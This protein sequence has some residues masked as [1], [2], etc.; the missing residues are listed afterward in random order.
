MLELGWYSNREPGSQ[1][2]RHEAKRARRFSRSRNSGG[3]NGGACTAAAFLE[4]FIED[5][6]P[7]VHIDIAGVTT[8][9]APTHMAPKGATGW[10]VAALDELVRSRE[11]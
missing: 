3:R 10:G 11:T 2:S 7:W 1:L 9:A 5:G 6:M 8:T 4:K